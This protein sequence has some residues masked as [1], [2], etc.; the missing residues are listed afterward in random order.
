[1]FG[2]DGTDQ[3]TIDNGIDEWRGCLCE[4]VRAKGGHF[5]QPLWQC[6]A[7]WQEAFQFLSNVTQF[8][9]C[10]FENYNKFQ[11][12]SKGIVAIYWTYVGSI[13]RILLK[14]YFCLQQ[15]KEFWKF[16]K[17][18]PSYRDEFGVLLFWDT[19]YMYMSFSMTSVYADPTLLVSKFVKNSHLVHK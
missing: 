2:M 14:I 12:L 7:I 5:E 6:S 8:L 19:V 17:N 11:L 10:F 15:L 3:T 18:W 9:H 4:C 16:V 1:M 13:I